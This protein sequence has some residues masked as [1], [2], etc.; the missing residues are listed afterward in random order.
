MK[1][2]DMN[3][4]MDDKLWMKSMMESVRKEPPENLSYIIMQVHMKV[5]VN[6][7]SLPPCK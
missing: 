6:K 1:K 7:A 5:F 2:D 3:E 4:I